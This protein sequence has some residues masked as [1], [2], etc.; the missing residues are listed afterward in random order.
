MALMSTR[1]RH[2]EL[3]I[4]FVLPAGCYVSYGS[5][6]WSVIAALQNHAGSALTWLAGWG[7]I[8]LGWFATYL[9]ARYAPRLR[10]S[11]DHLDSA[12]NKGPAA[13]RISPAEHLQPLARAIDPD[14]I[15]VS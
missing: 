9:G 10:H 8:A 11:L 14:P 15:A 4:P 3:S 5:V 7:T 2:I 1:I 13:G 12:T 6:T